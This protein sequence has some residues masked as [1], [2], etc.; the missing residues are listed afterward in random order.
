MKNNNSSIK[1]VVAVG[2]GAALFFVLGRFDLIVHH[3]GDFSLSNQSILTVCTK[4]SAPAPEPD[5]GSS[6]RNGQGHE[7]RIP[8]GIVP[9]Y[10]LYD[11]YSDLSIEFP[12]FLPF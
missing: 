6:D 7:F 2:I 4:P 11:K 5:R 3:I 8:S 10:R 1:P 9:I 12:E